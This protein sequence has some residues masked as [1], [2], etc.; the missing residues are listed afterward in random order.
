VAD[1]EGVHEGEGLG[2]GINWNG[3]T[4]R[5]H[6]DSPTILR[7]RASGTRVDIE[8]GKLTR[9]KR[10]SWMANQGKTLDDQGRGT[11]VDIEGEK[12]TRSR[13]KSWMADQGK[14][15]DDQG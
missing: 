9:S 2:F 7:D 1:C 3:E 6:S 8:G 4:S 15:L 10:K 14:T 5:L 11:R 13:R 12:L